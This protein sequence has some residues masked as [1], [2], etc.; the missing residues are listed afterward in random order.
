ME[1]QC[2]FCGLSFKKEKKLTCYLSGRTVTEGPGWNCHFFK[3]IIVEDGFPL[4]P[5]QHYIIKK[6]ELDRLK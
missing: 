5:H 1:K 2:A 6:S 3:E 4:T